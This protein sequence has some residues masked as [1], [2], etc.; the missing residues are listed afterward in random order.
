MEKR[1]SQIEREALAILWGSEKYHLYLYGKPFSVVTDHK[2]L[3]KIFND[4]AHRPPLRIER[5]I[6]KLQPYEFTV[7]YS[8]G[9]DNLA[10]Y[11]SRHPD[12]TP[13][14]SRR[15][16][17][18]AEE[19]INYVFSN[20]VPKALTQEEIMIATKSLRLNTGQWY[21]VK[22]S[23]DIDMTTFNALARIKTDLA[24]ANA[25]NTLLK[26]TRIVIP[27]SLQRRV[28]RLA[29]EGHE[30]IIKTKKLLREKV[31]FPGIDKLFE[32]CVA[33]CKYSLSSNKSS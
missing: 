6:L 3:V 27:Q 4:P 17:K 25:G 18:V 13:K 20:A 2:P 33:E 11:L 5:S 9:E 19:Y 8:P 12:L 14:Q 15:E 32:R 23:D 30:G 22:S 7:E 21:N 26:G 29:H 1:Y 28:I 16:E 24:T 10:D 31:W